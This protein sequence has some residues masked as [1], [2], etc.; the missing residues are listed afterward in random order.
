MN[1]ISIEN[2]HIKGYF[3]FTCFVNSNGS[4][5][6]I[7]VRLNFIVHSSKSKQIHNLNQFHHFFSLFLFFSFF[8]HFSR[9]GILGLWRESMP[10][11]SIHIG[12]ELYGSIFSI[13]THP[14]DTTA[15]VSERL[16]FNR[17]QTS[18]TKCT[19]IASRN[20]SILYR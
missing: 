3:F 6:I 2:Y 15:N 10:R 19:R 9:W 5:W 8:L 13:N 18:G 4:T 1:T 7:N 17:I 14:T 20:I 12:H 16:P 11:R